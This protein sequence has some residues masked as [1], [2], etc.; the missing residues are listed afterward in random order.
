[1]T[2]GER[3]THTHKKNR[4]VR[5]GKRDRQ[6]EAGMG[7]EREA[8]G[9]M[10]RERLESNQPSGQPQ[11]KLPSEALHDAPFLHTGLVSLHKSRWISQPL[12]K[13]SVAQTKVLFLRKMR[14]VQKAGTG[15]EEKKEEGIVSWLRFMPRQNHS[16]LA[17]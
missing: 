7:R 17:V 1:M 5:N 15:P 13:Y 9:E 2:D 11:E 4:E 8:K 16:L 3:E 12:P 10:E 14:N 6:A